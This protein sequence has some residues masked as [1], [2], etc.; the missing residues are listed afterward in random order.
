MVSNERNL[1]PSSLIEA[2]NVKLPQTSLDGLHASISAIIDDSRL[3]TQHQIQ[4]LINCQWQQLEK[5]LYSN[6]R[7]FMQETSAPAPTEPT[8]KMDIC[9]DNMAELDSSVACANNDAEPTNLSHR[10]SAETI[11]FRKELMMEMI[12]RGSSM[13][14]AGMGALV[15]ALHLDPRS[16]LTFMSRKRLPKN[17]HERCSLIVESH[18]FNVVVS[19]VILL[20]AVFIAFMTNSIM[21]EATSHWSKLSVG[22]TSSKVLRLDF[23][24]RMVDVAFSV[25][26]TLE[27]IIRLLADELRF[28]CGNTSKLNM[29]EL[30][31]VV[32]SWTDI[33][34]ANTQYLENISIVRVV[35]VFR[36]IRSVRVIR[37]LSLFQELRVVLLSLMGSVVPLFWTLFCL[38]IL[39]YVFIVMF[40]QGLA[41]FVMEQPGG[42]ELVQLEVIP[43]FNGFFRTFCSL[44]MAITGGINWEAYLR[45]MEKV[46]L[47]YTVLF[48]L[49]I[50]VM[51][52]GALNVITA[53]FVESATS[54]ARE[55]SDIAKTQEITRA[56][57]VAKDLKKL[58]RS[59][60]PSAA[61][62]ISLEDWEQQSLCREVQAYF[63][64]LN[65]DIHKARE[66][67]RLLD[68]DNS[69]YIDI[70]EFM[71]GCMQMQGSASSVNVE[72]LMST[73]RSL[74]Q[75]CN[76]IF[77]RLESKSGRDAKRTMDML[78]EILERVDGCTT[79]NTCTACTTRL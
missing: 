51:T 35:R 78:S 26:F 61:G 30:L 33:A 63:S 42:S 57:G 46:S 65:I 50:L 1:A 7:Q 69:G 58:F 76:E 11:E 18:L 56:P 17:F 9:Q 40:M 79:C 38:F 36:V 28:F 8:L 29:V 39:I 74:L 10:G 60:D 20:N 75:K 5:N 62:R 66:V 71:L 19:V 45:L 53:I 27:L 68:I 31:L 55:D 25:L 37:V 4:D 64:V 34:L 73:T 49:Y 43:H 21:S 67:F 59:M 77:T 47:L 48:I 32:A 16:F 52:F 44:L 15:S 6:F 23:W 54:K 22:E 3:Q 41:V 14:S 70:E 72:M 12:K 13:D 2:E 24:M